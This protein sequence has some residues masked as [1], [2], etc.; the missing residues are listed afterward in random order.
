[1]GHAR[2]RVRH[3]QVDRPQHR[4]G[5][6]SV[7]PST[8]RST[9]CCSRWPSRRWATP[10]P[11]S[12]C[13]SAR[14]AATWAC[15]SSASPRRWRSSPR[16]TSPRRDDDGA[17]PH[18]LDGAG[19]GASGSASIALLALPAVPWLLE[20][21]LDSA[22]ALHRRRPDG[23]RAGHRRRAA[24]DAG[25]R[26]QRR[27]RRQPAPGQVRR[28]SGWCRCIGKLVG[29]A[30][31]LV[32]WLR[33]GGGDVARDGADRRR[34]RAAGVLR[35]QARRRSCGSDRPTSPPRPPASSPASA[36]GCSPNCARTSLIEQ[37]DRIV[38]GLVPVGGRGDPLLRGVEALH[39]G[40]QRL[41]RRWCRRSGRWPP[42]C[43]PPAIS[44]ALQRL[45]LRM[46]KYTAALTWP[47]GWSLGLCAAPI[48]HYWVGPNPSPRTTS[49][50]R[51]WCATSSS[52]PTTTSPSACWAR[53]AGSARS[54]SRY[55]VPQ[56][57][58]NLVLS[59][60]AGAAAGDPRAWRSA[61]CCRSCMLEYAFLSYVLRDAGAA[62]GAT[63][64]RE[65]VRPTVAAGHAGLR[66]G[67][68]R[69]RRARAAVAVAVRRRR[70]VAAWSTAGSSG[71]ASPRAS[72]TTWCSS[73]P[74]PVRAL[75]AA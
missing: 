41:A 26:L 66:A 60:S 25:P 33:P 29:I 21:V 16:R 44:P 45:W 6:T 37:T 12:G 72:A 8:W 74:A 35:L 43:T 9:C 42:A 71:A 7:S 30:V 24:A 51:C 69:L 68:G 17:R 27:A 22:E 52:P 47:I 31:L 49:S 38:I 67:P 62:A 70:G 19:A 64:G 14:S 63:S 65:V 3:P 10:P 55:S 34:R 50:S 40:L 75:L 23:V 53:C 54:C 57:M 56:A 5:T 46:T 58:L 1:M 11:A 2:E 20:L 28:T 59:L 61:P 36:A 4:R 48:L 39:A 18:R 32:A 73:S 13:S 15:S